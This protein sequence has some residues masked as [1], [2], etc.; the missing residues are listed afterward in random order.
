M[1][2]SWKYT[3]K[4]AAPLLFIGGFIAV[5]LLV[6][7]PDDNDRQNT[8][9]IPAGSSYVVA[10]YAFTSTALAVNSTQKQSLIDGLTTEID[11]GISTSGLITTLTVGINLRVKQLTI[12]VLC[13]FPDVDVLNGAII[14][15]APGVLNAQP[16]IA[17]AVI[18]S[19]LKYTS[20]G[21]VTTTAETWSTSTTTA[22]TV[23]E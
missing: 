15:I 6:I 20:D 4:I 21:L 22:T 7:V 11:E 17:D 1:G 18:A 8:V 19:S 12:R 3:V 9:T 14:D 5:I 23:T 10:N 13:D 16:W 2:Q